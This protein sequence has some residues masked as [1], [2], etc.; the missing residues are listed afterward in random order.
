M[1][2]LAEGDPLVADQPLTLS[3]RVIPLAL[4]GAFD[5]ALSQATAMEG[6]LTSGAPPARWMALLRTLGC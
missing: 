1:A 6:W 5:S 3:R 2:D 4:L